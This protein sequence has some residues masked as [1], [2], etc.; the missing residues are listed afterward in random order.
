MLTFNPSSSHHIW[1]VSH[2]LEL[3]FMQQFQ[4]SPDCVEWRFSS[5]TIIK[6]EE[7]LKRRQWCGEREPFRFE[8]E[9]VWTSVLTGALLHD[10]QPLWRTKIQS[11]NVSS[12]LWD[13]IKAVVCPV[14]HG[15]EELSSFQAKLTAVGFAFEQREGFVFSTQVLYRNIHLPVQ[16]LPCWVSIWILKSFRAEH[17]LIDTL[18]IQAVCYRWQQE[19]IWAHH[20]PQ[21]HV[22]HQCS[23]GNGLTVGNNW[24]WWLRV[25]SQFDRLI[26][27]YIYSNL[28]DRK[29]CWGWV[30]SLRES[31]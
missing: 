22:L 30:T 14:T 12:A 26:G 7:E 2:W 3:I 21:S 17:Q 18:K 27:L 29:Q 9:G 8:D 25:G 10:S 19:H 20:D 24:G 23:A 15:D 28:R 1:S 6:M 4:S 13:P 16:V 5:H 31:G 11:S